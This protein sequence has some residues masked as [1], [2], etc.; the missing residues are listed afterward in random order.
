VIRWAPYDMYWMCVKPSH[1]ERVS[2]SIASNWITC[3]K[4]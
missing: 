1:P 4:R 2:T 3:T